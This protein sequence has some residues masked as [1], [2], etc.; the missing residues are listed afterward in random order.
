MRRP[1]PI[2]RPQVPPGPLRDLK[3]LLYEL[4][5]QAG[6]PSLDEITAL[7][8][9]DDDLAGAPGRDTVRR[10]VGEPVPPPAQADV[11]AV[12]TVLARSG[13]WAPEDAVQ[14]VR[15]LWVKSRMDVPA[16]TPVGE[17]TDPFALEVHR[18]I[19]IE[20]AAGA[21]E[22]PVLPP[23]LAREHD[24][25]LAE[26]T[27]RVV[28]GQS[29]IVSLVG[30][31]STGKTRACWEAVQG[32]PAGWRLWH[33][34]FPDRAAAFLSELERVR[35]RTVVWL[36][37]AQ[38]YL[39]TAQPAVGEQVAAGLRDLLRAP[40]RGPVLVLATLWPEH[41]DLLTVPTAADPYAQARA[42]LAGSLVRVP[43]SFGGTRPA[44]LAEAAQR[45]PR[46]AQAVKEARDGHIAQYLAGVPALLERYQAAPPPAR[47]LIDAA[48]DARRL[49]HGPALPH[50]LLEV[51]APGYLTDQEWAQTRDDWFEEALA[52]TAQP[53]RGALG[54][55]TR[56][57]PR[58]APVPRGADT[59]PHART[60]A[61][62]YRLADYLE[63]AGRRQRA[64]ALPPRSLWEALAAS[65]DV[66][67]LAVIADQADA[68][69]LYRDAAQM[70]KY[71]VAA[72][73]S[74]AALRLVSRARTIDPRLA[75][76]AAEWVAARQSLGDPRDVARLVRALWKA[77]AGQSVGPLADRAAAHMSVDD[78]HGI[79]ELLLEL[80]K[81]GAEQAISTL[82]GRAAAH[83]PLDQVGGVA[84]LLKELRRVNAEQ[85]VT[86]LAGRAAAH[87]PV[88]EPGAVAALLRNVHEAGCGQAVA[89]LLSRDPA[90]RVALDDTSGVARLLKALRQVDAGQAVAVLAGRIAD[91]A[92]LDNAYR[93]ADLLKGMRKVGAEQPLTLLADRAAA[94]APLSNVLEA[95]HL[96]HALHEVGSGTA[97]TAL[98]GRVA[99]GAPLDR[100][101]DVANLL[102]AL[103]KVGAGDAVT[104]LAG[105]AAAD[106]PLGHPGEIAR[107]LRALHG[108]NAEESTAV[109]TRRACDHVTL[110]SPG[111]VARLIR[112]LREL[113]GNDG[114]IASLLARAPADQVALTDPGGVAY[115]LEEL[116]AVDAA[117]TIASLL[118]RRPAV[119]V[120]LD[121]PGDIA[122]LVRALKAAGAV[123]AAARLADRAAQVPLDEPAGIARLIRAL[124]EGG[125]AH[126]AAALAER[127]ALIPLDRPHH[128]D[129]LSQALQK[130][131][132]EHAVAT[133]AER[134]ATAGAF[135][136]FLDA[137]PGRAE[138]FRFGR[139]HDGTPEPAWQWHDLL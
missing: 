40:G 84:H 3:D 109:L 103:W 39:R 139:A 13:G 102:R 110:G 28:D 58:P 14:R 6:A 33:P 32:L 86:D 65:A 34:I 135:T 57:K 73:H 31:S 17:L 29:A 72:G 81:A 134:A 2:P 42:L 131:G 82:A 119:Q 66:D 60:E 133:L 59:A 87:A 64:D 128:A 53:C 20:S 101:G 56:S 121:L 30:G 71:A 45:D 10:I 124:G 94:H 105:R 126:A 1:R 93:L 8:A 41:W 80:W 67:D 54:P 4:Y 35:P 99:G 36:N 77:G 11:V 69:G 114:A 125:T 112:A 138:R 37:D 88:D 15:E 118:A 70:R 76:H 62:R 7:I 117:P 89:T 100:P 16:G 95:A 122:R 116:R 19:V 74:T 79:G 47:A 12:A 5:L 52:Y 107:L 46:L 27:A 123:E 50:A 127:A 113:P 48:V 104:A 111:D 25:R 9:A 43:E 129:A 21:P 68:R 106:V 55:L 22:L 115:L 18:P 96:L 132:A 120:A 24:R 49:G 130:V 108:A 23:Y 51:A 61:P 90:E 136:I 38:L 63:Q 44:E 92:S 78:P 91:H 137:A 75:G 26:I 97:V 83:A 85:A 98:A